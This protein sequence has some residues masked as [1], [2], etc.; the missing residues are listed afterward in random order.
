[1][2][3]IGV[4]G[5]GS[6]MVAGGGGVLREKVEYAEKEKKRETAVALWGLR[7]TEVQDS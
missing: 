6:E 4:G 1:M 2:C 3:A 7:C 5:Q